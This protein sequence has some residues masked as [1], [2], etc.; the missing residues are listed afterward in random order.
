M[1]AELPHPAMKLHPRADGSAIV[2]AVKMTLPHPY[3]KTK[4]LYFGGWATNA[5]KKPD[6][7]YEAQVKACYSE[8]SGNIFASYATRAI[9]YTEGGFTDINVA[10]QCARH[11]R[12][13][14]SALV[15][16]GITY[17]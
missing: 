14:F 15:P 11:V 4:T 2:K 12:K 17:S 5:S 9:I 8:R 13:Q 7:T 3:D 6:G 1:P 16:S 10:R